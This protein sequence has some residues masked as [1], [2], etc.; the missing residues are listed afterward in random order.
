MDQLL[1]SCNPN[2][3]WL[4]PVII[5]SY[6]QILKTFHYCLKNHPLKDL[7]TD[8][9]VGLKVN[10]TWVNSRAHQIRFLIASFHDLP[11]VYINKQIIYI[12]VNMYIYIHTCIYIYIMSVMY[13]YTPGTVVAFSPTF[14]LESLAVQP[15]ACAMGWWLKPQLW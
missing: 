8:V 12:Y 10:Y 15:P 7:A 3:F 11:Y 2:F 14:C 6:I 1:H 5:T 9:R 4:L 13:I